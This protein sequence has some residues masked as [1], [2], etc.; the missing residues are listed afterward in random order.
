MDGL[1]KGIVLSLLPISELR[2]GIPVAMAS[3]VG[4]VTAFIT[5]VIANILVIIPVFF[6]LDNIHKYLMKIKIYE[7]I[8]T[9]Y[10]ES[11]RKRVELGSF[12][13]RGHTFPQ[14]RCIYR[15]P[16]SVVF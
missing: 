11:V 7:K 16:C 5:C 10:L 1:I 12:P 4:W 6:F 15:M 13:F 14:Y 9:T 8:F 3:G 2:G